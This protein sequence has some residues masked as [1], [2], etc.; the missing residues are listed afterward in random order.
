VVVTRPT[1]CQQCKADLER[2][3]GRIEELEC[4]VTIEAEAAAAL[5]AK[6]E[7]AVARVAELEDQ[8][9][10]LEAIRD[11][12]PAL[13]SDLEAAR[14]AKRTWRQGAEHAQ[15]RVKELEAALSSAVDRLNGFLSAY[16]GD[17]DPSENDTKQL[18]AR[19]IGTLQTSEVT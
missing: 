2:A 3:R 13:V 9:L 5:T 15:A 1:P 11:E 16:E 8:Q 14:F 4:E 18:V 6:L 10:A 19:L 12:R 17:P 7:A